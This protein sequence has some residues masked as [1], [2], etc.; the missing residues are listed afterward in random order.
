[1]HHLSLNVCVCVCISQNYFKNLRM[2]DWQSRFASRL[3]DV[4]IEIDVYTRPFRADVHSHKLHIAPNVWG[5]PSSQAQS[6]TSSL[7]RSYV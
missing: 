3:G 2:L 4:A 1:M 7:C 6:F 5:G